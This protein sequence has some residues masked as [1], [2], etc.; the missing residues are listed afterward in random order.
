MHTVLVTGTTGFVGSALAASL[1]ARSIS[2]MA[3]SRNDPDGERTRAAIDAAAK[4]F[5]LDISDALKSQ[6]SIVNIDQD[7]LSASLDVRALQKVTAAWHFATEMSYS[8]RSLT[9]SFKTNVTGSSEL[10]RLLS[11]HVPSCHRFYYVSTAYVSRPSESTLKETLAMDGLY[12]TPYHAS[13]LTT[14]FVLYALHG[15][16][17]LP[18]TLFRPT[19]IVGHEHTGWARCNGFGL[20]MLADAMDAVIRAGLSELTLDIEPGARPDLIPVNRLVDDALVLTLRTDVARGL[21]IFHCSGGLGLS[22]IEIAALFAEAFGVRVSFGAP[23][24]S[25]DEQIGWGLESRK[26]F[27]DNEWRFDRSQLDKALKRPHGLPAISLDTLRHL[28][29]WYKSNLNAGTSSLRLG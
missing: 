16:H 1:L 27:M 20:Y 17:R 3:L 5:R 13:K 22:F 18:L 2:V 10:Y 29:V 12:V 4:G 11:I 9:Q 21:E 28:I 7:N 24:T 15:L 23:V 19:V 6:L 25:L 8:N 14:E 26:P